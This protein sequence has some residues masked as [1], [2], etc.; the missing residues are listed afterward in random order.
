M[1]YATAA[2]PKAVSIS[3]L[4]TTMP[5]AYGGYLSGNNLDAWGGARRR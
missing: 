2:V 5:E 1:A 3:T 4:Q